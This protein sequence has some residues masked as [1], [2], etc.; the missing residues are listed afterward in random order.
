MWI[1]HQRSP[2][3]SGVNRSSKVIMP[4]RC[5]RNPFMIETFAQFQE[6]QVNHMNGWFRFLSPLSKTCMVSVK[7]PSTTDRAQCVTARQEWVTTTLQPSQTW[8]RKMVMKGHFPSGQNCKHALECSC[9][10]S[11]ELIQGVDIHGQLF[12][13][14]GMLKEQE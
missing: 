10:V 3:R 13:H 5:I 6:A 11:E 14:L 1:C 8:S 9:C 2:S 12:G 7:F 4:G